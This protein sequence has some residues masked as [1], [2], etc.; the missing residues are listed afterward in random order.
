MQGVLGMSVAFQHVFSL[1]FYFD[2]ITLFVSPSWLST[3]L[4][5]GNTSGRDGAL[6]GYFFLIIT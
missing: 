6:H 4:A 2:Y 5:R 3:C 1:S